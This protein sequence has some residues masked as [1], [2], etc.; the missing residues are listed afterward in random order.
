MG[1]TSCGNRFVLDRNENPPLSRDRMISHFSK[2]PRDSHE[3][4]PD[5]V[6]NL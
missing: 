2:F 6:Y 4:N 3:A 5:T 1:D